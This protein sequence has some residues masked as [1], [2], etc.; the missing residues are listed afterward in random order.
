MTQI[1]N[2]LA[3]TNQIFN[4]AVIAAIIG[5]LVALPGFLLN[6]QNSRLQRKK[7]ERDEIYKKINSF[8]GPIRL[9]LKTS[10]EFYNLFCSSIKQR[11]G[12]DTFRTLPYILDG[13]QLNKTEKTILK[14]I[15]K[16]GKNIEQIINNN[17]GLID[18]DNLHKEMVQLATHLQ[19]IREAYEGGYSIGSNKLPFLENK[20]FPDIEERVDEMFWKLKNELKK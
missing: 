11:L 8:Y 13:N 10:K 18:D 16:I 15:L 6:S 12:L 14:Q 7:S 9:Q 4:P 19:I 3:T 17:A 1:C 5:A 20:T 2:T